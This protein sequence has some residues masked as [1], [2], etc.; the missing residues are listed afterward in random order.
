MDLEDCAS[1]PH[2]SL[3]HGGCPVRTLAA[4]GTT[5]AKDPYCEAYKVVFTR[6][7]ELAVEV[8]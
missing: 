6:C 8:E 3:C 1:C 4:K 5:L 7:R 2:L